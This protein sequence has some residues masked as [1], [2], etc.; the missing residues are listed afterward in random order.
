MLVSQAK[1]REKFYNRNRITTGGKTRSRKELKSMFA[2]DMRKKEG[3]KASAN[4]QRGSARKTNRVLHLIRGKAV[5][6]AI[7]IVKF[8]PTRAARLI[9]K[10]ILSAKANAENN[11]NWD[12]ENIIVA[13]AYVEQGPTIPRIRPMSMG[14]VGR[15]R[16]RTC[17]TF[18][19]LTEKQEKQT[20]TAKKDGETKK[21]DQ[22]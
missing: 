17:S 19:V 5:N 6:E 2:A 12:A 1:L 9:E 14:R 7:A 20:I 4:V 11:R 21:A 10:V 3:V 22:K 18:I 16:K 15:I 8:T 13:R